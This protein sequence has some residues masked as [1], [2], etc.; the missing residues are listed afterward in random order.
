AR[1][2]AAVDLPNEVLL[3]EPPA[4]PAGDGDEDEHDVL[5]RRG[6]G[7]LEHVL[8]E[9]AA[10]AEAEVVEQDP[11]DL[12]G[13]GIADGLVVE[14]VDAALERLAERAEPA[15]RVEGLVVDAVE[16]EALEALEGLRLDALAAAHRLARIAVLVDEPVGRPGEIVFEGVGRVA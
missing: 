11:H 3:D 4:A 14:R 8:E 13:P 10:L 15:R 2:F 9:V 1:R 7:R 6:D 5:R 16:R 12:A